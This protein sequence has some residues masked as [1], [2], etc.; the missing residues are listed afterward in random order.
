MNSGEAA[1]LA[2]SVKGGVAVAV[3]ENS[4]SFSSTWQLNSAPQPVPPKNGWCGQAVVQR[5]RDGHV[6]AWKA[7]CPFYTRHSWLPSSPRGVVFSFA[8]R[9]LWERLLLVFQFQWRQSWSISGLSSVLEIRVSTGSVQHPPSSSPGVPLASANR[10]RIC[11]HRRR[12]RLSPLVGAFTLD[13]LCHRAY[14][15]DHE[16]DGHRQVPPRQNVLP[17]IERTCVKAAAVSR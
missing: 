4:W 2:R 6:A 16:A 10:P 3:A 15:S 1:R 17:V 5:E 14:R 13:N 12:Q 9:S 11:R 7:D 8:S